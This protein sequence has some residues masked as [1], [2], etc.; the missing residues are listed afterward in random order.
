MIKEI[1]QNIK[2]TAQTDKAT[3]K[4][5]QMKSTMNSIPKQLQLKTQNYDKA[6]T[7]MKNSMLG[8]AA[9]ATA[10]V[11]VI[12]KGFLGLAEQQQSIKRLNTA[13]QITGTNATISAASLWDYFQTLQTGIGQ[14]ADELAN[15]AS[16]FVSAGI[17]S[18]SMVRQY[19]NAAIGLAQQTGKSVDEVSDKLIRAMQGQ[20]KGLKQFGIAT[21]TGATSQQLLSEALRRGSI[22]FN[23][24]DTNSAT[25]SMMIFRQSYQNLLQGFAQKFLPAIS[26]TINF[27]A[28]NLNVIGNILLGATIFA[29]M[30]SI[31]NLGKAIYVITLGQGAAL[32][33]QIKSKLSIVE[34]EIQ[35]YQIM[36]LESPLLAS[37][38]KALDQRL[39]TQ[40]FYNKKLD[41]TNTL[42][43]TL[44]SIFSKSN[45]IIL[46]STVALTLILTNWTKI[47]QKITGVTEQT[48]RHNEAIVNATTEY[49]NYKSKLDANISSLQTLYGK[50]KLSNIE[51]HKKKSLI[52]DLNTNYGDLLTNNIEYNDTLQTMRSKLSN[53]NAGLQ[54]QK[55]LLIDT[56]VLKA[57]ES[58]ITELVQKRVKVETALN[59]L[60]KNTYLGDENSVKQSQALTKAKNNLIA[61]DKD[62]NKLL[63]DQVKLQTKINDVLKRNTGPG[64][65]EGSG[66]GSQK[67]SLLDLI[68]ARLDYQKV[69]NNQAGI[70]QNLN[71]LK[72][73]YGRQLTSN[74]NQDESKTL[75]I[76]KN[77]AEVEKQI[78]DIKLNKTSNILETYSAWANYYTAINDIPKALEYLMQVQV[79][80]NI[81]A[82]DTTLTTLEQIAALSKAAEARKQYAELAGRNVKDPMNG[83]SALQQ[84][85]LS[86]IQQW[87]SQFTTKAWQTTNMLQLAFVDT[88]NSISVAWDS[89]ASNIGNGFAAVL[90]QGQ[91][92]S[93]SMKNIFKDFASAIIAQIGRIITKLI[94]A[95]TLKTLLGGFLGGIFGGG[96]SA[97]TLS[98]NLLSSSNLAS[99]GRTDR[100]TSS[101]NSIISIS[102]SNLLYSGRNSMINKLD[103]VINAVN[104]IEPVQ[105]QTIDLPTLATATK[106]GNAMILQGV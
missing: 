6:I 57:N 86:P 50:Q 8:L 37:Q 95:L 61:V 20:T 45:L 5:N 70:L 102:T 51:L 76:L 17:A 103:E 98:G 42:A 21:N 89:L 101:S 60:L 9:I 52:D 24:I 74:D 62:L 11:A 47:K 88:F 35:K 34:L 79:A 93:K 104:S 41:E 105:T 33:K 71:D 87:M 7:S 3:A 73:E 2:I 75:Q 32:I 69:L 43:G 81:I 96:S 72:A 26:S 16:K 44:S 58:K 91:S 19:T 18:Q 12:R 85:Q 22:A 29:A 4:L 14:S 46:A 97:A 27:I 80:Y 78:T 68:K 83:Q 82:K 15:I 64:S 10:A 31:Y 63:E 59:T 67:A 25:R 77:I 55:T 49:V 100:N 38:Q 66:T 92:F 106:I 94:I 28:K 99:V 13:I 23:N 54:T 84:I 40:T 36:L 53:V 48:R 30:K 1:I 39:A 65:G 56:A 90:V